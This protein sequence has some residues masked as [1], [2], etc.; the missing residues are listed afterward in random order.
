MLKLIAIRL[1][2]MGGLIVNTERKDLQ[3]QIWREIV[4]A[5]KFMV[6]QVE[7]SAVQP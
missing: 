3:A 1:N 2:R 5:L 6:P 4:D 7:Q